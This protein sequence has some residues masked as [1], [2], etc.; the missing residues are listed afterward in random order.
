MHPRS[1]GI[2]IGL[3]P[4]KNL[5]ASLVW[6]RPLVDGDFTHAGESRIL[7]VLRTSF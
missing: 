2:G 1:W 4:L 7:F 3:A 5:T 6:A